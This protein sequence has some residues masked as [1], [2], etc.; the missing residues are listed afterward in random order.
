MERV[1]LWDGNSYKPFGNNYKPYY[2]LRIKPDVPVFSAPYN[3]IH[4]SIDANTG[5]W[6]DFLNAPVTEPF[7]PVGDWLIDNAVPAD[8]VGYKAAVVWDR[9]LLKLANEPIIQNGYTLVP[10]RE[11]LTKLGASIS[12]D[13]AKRIV[14]ASKNGITVE[15]TID[16]ATAVING[17]AQKFDAPARITGGRT[18]IPA[19]LV[20]ETFG[21]KVGWNADSRLVLVTTDNSLP[22]LTAKEMEQLRFKAHLNW[23]S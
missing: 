3:A 9:E 21:A 15:L 1:Y 16:S 17:K 2:K 7:P 14:K 19:R 10:F 8:A 18:F 5:E 11:L 6:S 4:P 23:L 20:L 22:Q 12:W 13:P